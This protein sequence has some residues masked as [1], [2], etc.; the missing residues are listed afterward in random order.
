MAGRLDENVFRAFVRWSQ[1]ALVDWSAGVVLLGDAS[2]R[3]G[4][5]RAL[6]RYEGLA[7][8]WCVEDGS[9]LVESLEEWGQGGSIERSEAFGMNEASEIVACLD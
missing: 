1:G 3:Y 4:V 6:F 2:Q 9:W 8:R 5:W 7:A